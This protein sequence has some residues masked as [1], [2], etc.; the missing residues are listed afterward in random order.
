MPPPAKW[1]LVTVDI[2]YNNQPPSV[3]L[4]QWNNHQQWRTASSA[5]SLEQVS[6][7]TEIPK[8]A[9]GWL[10]NILAAKQHFDKYSKRQIWKQ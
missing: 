7:W 10:G 1:V 8:P 2:P 4:A 5:L 6:H 3:E 9:E